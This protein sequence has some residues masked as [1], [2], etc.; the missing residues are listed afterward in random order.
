[1]STWAILFTI[2]TGAFL[3]KLPRHKAAL[4]LVIG[5]TYITLGPSLDLGPFHFTVIRVLIAVGVLRV[6]VNG[7]RLKRGW[8]QLDVLI[9][10]WSFWA[11]VSSVCHK[12]IVSTLVFRLGL[13]YNALGLY[14]LIRI[15][16]QDWNDV[17]GICGFVIVALV[18]IAAEMMIEATTGRNLFS[19]FGGVADLS[20]IRGGKIRAQGPF[21]HSILAGTVGAVSF[22]MGVL[23]WRTNRRLAWIGFASTLLIVALSRS[24]GPILTLLSAIIAISAWL[25]RSHMR[26][27]QWT[28]CF[29]F[30]ALALVMKAPIYYLLSRVDLTGSS[31]GYHRAILIEAAIE[32]LDEWWLYGTDY[33]QHWTPNAGFGDDTD[34]TNHYIR[35][36][37]WGGL[38]LVGL[39]VWILAL[40]FRSVGAVLR[41]RSNFLLQEQFVTW[42]LG[43]MLFAH[44]STMISVSYFDQSIFF[45]YLVH[46]GHSL[47]IT[48]TCLG[49]E[50]SEP[51]VVKI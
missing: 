15:F 49:V 20:E 16:I 31:T 29:V 12:D 3:L 9:V 35:L 23:F 51:A 27:I 13:A 48:I 24:S 34:V 32:H 36:G 4:P 2:V 50:G 30:I 18:P 22:P 14:F 37:I 40:G 5:A 11:V 25:I 17:I 44:A 10:I 47:T 1:M 42:S 46:R 38:P 8:T 41:Q 28:A 21:A 43:C 39:F 33:T 6:V 45:L 26:A 7:E 19:C